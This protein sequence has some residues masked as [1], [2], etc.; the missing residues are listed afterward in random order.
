MNNRHV[1]SNGGGIDSNTTIS[2]LH[3]Y[4]AS[5]NSG[6]L[7]LSRFAKIGYAGLIHTLRETVGTIMT[8]GRAAA[9]ITGMPH[10][11]NWRNTVEQVCNAAL[12][13]AFVIRCNCFDST[14]IYFAVIMM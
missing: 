13:L 1:L 8:T 10:G 12:P 4:S 14:S 9:N 3:N 11:P 7:A 6:D 2:T 5:H